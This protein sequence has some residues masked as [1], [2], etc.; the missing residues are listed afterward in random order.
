LIKSG[1]SFAINSAKSVRKKRIIK[2][3]D[4]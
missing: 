4:E 2:I 3:I 1:L